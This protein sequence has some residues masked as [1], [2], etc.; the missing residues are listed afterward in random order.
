MS[1]RNLLAW[2]NSQ[3]ADSQV[4]CYKRS[5]DSSPHVSVQIPLYCLA[6]RQAAGLVTSICQ[7]HCSETRAARDTSMHRCLHPIHSH[8]HYDAFDHP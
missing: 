8:N 3:D 4:V 7:W 2:A 5:V 1:L 6:P